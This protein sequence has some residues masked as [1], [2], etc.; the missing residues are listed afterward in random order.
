MGLTGQ[1]FQKWKGDDFTIQFTIT[2]AQTLSGYIAEW[3]M[4]VTADSGSALITKLSSNGGI[5]FDAN[6]V[7][8]PIASAETKTITPTDPIPAGTY[9]HELHLTDPQSKTTVAAIGTITLTNPFHKR[10]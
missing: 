1:S 9:Y 2:D 10:T 7:L 8:I 4:S 5:T 6:K 3:F